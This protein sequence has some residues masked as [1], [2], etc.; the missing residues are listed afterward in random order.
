MGYCAK[1]IKCI[2]KLIDYIGRYMTVSEILKAI[3]EKIKNLSESKQNEIDRKVDNYITSSR[4]EYQATIYVLYIENIINSE[5][6]NEFNNQ[7]EA[8]K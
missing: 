2:I 6:Y 4:D 5:E 3:V 1:V 7:Y 8:Q